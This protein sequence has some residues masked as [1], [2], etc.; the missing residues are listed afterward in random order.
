M[1]DD[2]TTRSPPEGIKSLAI[3]Q[4]SEWLSARARAG[5]WG[6]SGPLA[7]QRGPILLLPWGPGSQ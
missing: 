1:G 4:L 2:M 5:W 3:H 6:H 7:P